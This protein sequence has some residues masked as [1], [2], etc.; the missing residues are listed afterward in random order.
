MINIEKAKKQ[1]E[2]HTNNLNIQDSKVAKKIAHMMR[3]SKI[4]EKIATRISIDRR[5]S[6]IGTTN[7]FT[8]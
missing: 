3:V 7:W 6:E 5:T 2:K 1:F 8:S 4:S